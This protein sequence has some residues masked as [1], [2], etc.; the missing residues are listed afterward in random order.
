VGLRR[1]GER[2]VLMWF[3]AEFELHVNP[4]HGYA[5]VWVFRGYK[6]GNLYLYPGATRDIYPWVSHTRGIPYLY[7]NVS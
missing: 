4:L 7:L 5:R 6:L 3:Q 2:M 1:D